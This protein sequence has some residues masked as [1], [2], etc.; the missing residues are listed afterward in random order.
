MLDEIDLDVI[1]SAETRAAIL[2]LA[3]RLQALEDQIGALVT[4]NVS[5]DKPTQ[6][7]TPRKSAPKKA[8]A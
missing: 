7:R 6:D 4:G 8:G 2:I 1:P 3:G 5:S